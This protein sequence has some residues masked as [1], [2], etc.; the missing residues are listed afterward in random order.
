MNGMRVDCVAGAQGLSPHVDAWRALVPRALEQ[1]LNFEPEPLLDALQLIDGVGVHTLLFFDGDRLCGLWPIRTKSAARAPLLRWHCYWHGHLMSCAPLLDADRVDDCLEAF[2]DWLDT[3]ARPALFTIEEAVDRSAIW[4][5]L[6][7]RCR[8]GTHRRRIERLEQRER[9]ALI[10]VSGS[11]EAY[12]QRLSTARARSALRRK[13]RQL[14]ALGDW[15]VH[16]FDG[17]ARRGDASLGLTALLTEL[18]TLEAAG[19]KGRAGSA[20]S[21]QADTKAYLTRLADYAL[22]RNR[23]LLLVARLD[24][25]AV[26]AQFGLLN[27]GEALL[28]KSAFDED[29][30]RY[31]PGVHLLMDAVAQRFVNARR[32]GIDS[33]AEPTV[34]LY[35]DCLAD[36]RHIAKYRLC[37]THPLAQL[38]LWS[39]GTARD[40]KR[41][42]RAS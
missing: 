40:V 38:A 23:L 14:D 2:L 39:L 12:L 29:L 37:S 28:Y 18:M 9:A 15:Q 16:G 19:W 4:P 34:R 33:C 41:R 25:R 10:Q 24:G 35:R 42:L 26:A 36:R 22:A 7:Q 5:R 11:H 32:G 17:P 6:L 1:N 13:R 3:S 21:Q 20:M 27:G 31:S 30:A 8:D